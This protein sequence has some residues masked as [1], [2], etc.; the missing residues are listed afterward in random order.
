MLGVEN[1]PREDRIV[2]NVLQIAD[3]KNATTEENLK[4]KCTK[5]KKTNKQR[6]Y[7]NNNNKQTNNKGNCTMN[8]Y[9]ASVSE[10][11]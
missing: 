11:G 9:S 8:K 10:L 4:A 5:E 1:C 3:K 7:K 6:N 2:Q